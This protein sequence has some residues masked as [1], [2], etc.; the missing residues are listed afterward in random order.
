MD[1]GLISLIILLFFGLLVFSL[2][3]ITNYIGWK[4]RHD[5]EISQKMDRIIDLLEKEYK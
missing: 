5:K 2:I 1:G 4:R 3:S